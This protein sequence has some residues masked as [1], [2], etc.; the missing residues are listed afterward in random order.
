MN[1]VDRSTSIDTP[2]QKIWDTLNESLIE[3]KPTYYQ[4]MQSEIQ[5]FIESNAFAFSSK[6]DNEILS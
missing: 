2:P 3:W 5:N 1:K 4:L 6:H